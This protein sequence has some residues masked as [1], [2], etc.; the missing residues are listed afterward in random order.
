MSAIA[1]CTIKTSNKTF[2]AKLDINGEHVS[3]ET[4]EDTLKFSYP[5]LQLFA[6]G[7]DPETNEKFLLMLV[8]G[9]DEDDDG[10]LTSIEYKVYTDNIDAIYEALQKNQ[11]L[12]PDPPSDEEPPV[13]G[14]GCMAPGPNGDAGQFEDI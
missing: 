7:S 4:D 8:N 13:Q 2:H 10:D 3:I 9:G 6:T 5:E 12:H 14:F 11:E 1:E